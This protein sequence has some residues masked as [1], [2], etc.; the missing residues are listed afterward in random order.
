[1]VKN[2][3]N[4]QEQRIAQIELADYFLKTYLVF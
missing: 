3:M 1:M 4:G 2:M